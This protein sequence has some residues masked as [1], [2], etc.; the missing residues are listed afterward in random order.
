MLVVPQC[1]ASNI[2]IVYTEILLVY[3]CTSNSALALKTLRIS[4]K[5]RKTLVD[6]EK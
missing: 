6:A 4:I 5:I 1:M 2:K 3:A